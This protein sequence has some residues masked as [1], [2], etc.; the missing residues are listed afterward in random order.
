MVHSLNLADDDLFIRDREKVQLIC[1]GYQS[2]TIVTLGGIET[3]FRSFHILI[4]I[5]VAWLQNLKR[6][7]RS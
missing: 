2:R 7:L 1:E 6:L 5:N 4:E 3:E